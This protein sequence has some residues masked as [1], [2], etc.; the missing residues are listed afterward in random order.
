V[1]IRKMKPG[2]EAAVS[3]V[4][5]DTFRDAVAPAFSQEGIRVFQAYAAPEA[6]GKG[7]G[8]GI[9][10]RGGRRRTHGERN[11]ARADDSAAA[12]AMK[13]R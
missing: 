6:R 5:I 7:V 2:G 9:P 11:T 8:Q 3:A 13:G 12:A 10:L 4:A 1:R